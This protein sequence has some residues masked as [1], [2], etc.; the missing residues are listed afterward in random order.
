MLELNK[1][2]H[3]HSPELIKELDDN[4]IDCLITSPPY[5]GLRDYGLDPVIWDGADGCEHKWDIANKKGITGGTN[6]S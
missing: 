6:R 3:G 2:Y 1:I 5:W 4:S